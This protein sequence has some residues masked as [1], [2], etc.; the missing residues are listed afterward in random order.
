MGLTRHKLPHLIS[1]A[2]GLIGT[3][4]C[5]GRG[6]APNSYFGRMLA[7]ITL[8]IPGPRP[9]PVETS[10]PR[11]LRAVQTSALDLGMRIYRNTTLLN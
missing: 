11:R 3:I 2:E 8:G 6:I 1:P 10:A 4:G 7:D 9:L 5:N